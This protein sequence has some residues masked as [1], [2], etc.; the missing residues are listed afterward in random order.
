MDCSPPGSSVHGIFQARILEWVA[1]SFS[2]FFFFFFL[3]SQFDCFLLPPTP[4]S[5][6][7]VLMFYIW[8]S[9]WGF[10]FSCKNYQWLCPQGNPQALRNIISTSFE[11]NETSVSPR[12]QIPSQF[13]NIPD[14]FP[15]NTV[16]HQ[17]YHTV[18]ISETF[19][20][21]LSHKFFFVVCWLIGW[22]CLPSICIQHLNLNS[23]VIG[24]SS[25]KHSYV[26][27]SSWLVEDWL[28]WI[29]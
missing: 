11:Q 2:I 14:T 16:W 25:S 20:L 12:F 23:V 10:F 15:A 8:S 3:M 24:G 9:A 21:D 7:W 17:T 22:F 1:I 29:T 19:F 28:S 6:S 18:V 13:Q 4:R 26:R 27:R 5:F